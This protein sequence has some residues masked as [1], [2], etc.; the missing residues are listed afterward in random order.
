MQKYKKYKN[1]NFAPATTNT[2]AMPPNTPPHPTPVPWVKGLTLLFIYSVMCALM[3]GINDHEHMTQ[4][5]EIEW[6][7][8]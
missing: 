2:P 3:L 1:T 6:K 5:Y 8:G 4:A 7:L